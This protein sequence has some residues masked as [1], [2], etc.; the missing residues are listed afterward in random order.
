MTTPG[1]G[2]QPPDP[3]QG[4]GPPQTGW[5]GQP[6]GEDT[7]WAVLAHLSIFA[8]ALVGPL[9]IY[10]VKKDQSPFTR[11]HAAEALN[12]HITLAIAAVVSGILILV[13]VGIFMLLILAVAGPVLGI[14]AALAASRREAYR[15]PFT[16][17]FIS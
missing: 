14:I 17:R 12:F 10:L 16:I 8:F 15:Y 11:H 4:W 7:V 2:G 3:P 5:T 6:Q 13:I 1:W 9:V